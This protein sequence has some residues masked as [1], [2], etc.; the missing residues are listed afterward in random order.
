MVPDLRPDEQFVDKEILV[1]S[2][3]NFADDEQSPL[4]LSRRMNVNNLDS[5]LKT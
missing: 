1:K 4:H 5:M 3:F 2:C